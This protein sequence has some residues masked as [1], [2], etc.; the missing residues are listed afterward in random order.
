MLTSSRVV[1]IACVFF[2]SAMTA[3]SVRAEEADKIFPVFDDLLYEG[4]PDLAVYGVRAIDGVYAWRF[5]PDG[6]PTDDLPALSQIEQAA[7][8]PFKSQVIVLDVEHWPTREP[9]DW[10]NGVEKYRTLLRQFKSFLVPGKLVGYFGHPPVMDY[11]RASQDSE[12][13][14]YKEWQRD[15]DRLADWASE[16]DILF[17]Q[18]YAFYPNKEG[19]VKYATAQIS[20]AR[21]LG[22][23][24]PV[25]VYL[26]PRYHEAGSMD[27]QYVDDDYWE[28]QLRT[29][30]DH[31]DGIV[32]WGGWKEAWDEDASW[33]RVTKKFLKELYPLKVPTGLSIASPESLE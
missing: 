31:A 1:V 3:I 10:L 33:W 18:L 22:N 29:A 25:Y 9:Y 6:K 24:K 5:W 28:L 23:G 12:T 19:W 26:W 14:E 20:E 13:L 32:L 30:R 16:V 2:A 8:I 4:K 15:N 17:P 7:K 11:W 27:N 21:R